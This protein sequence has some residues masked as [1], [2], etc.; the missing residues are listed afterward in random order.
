[1]TFWTVLASILEGLGVDFG[2]FWMTFLQ[3]LDDLGQQFG[4][5]HQSVP[6]NGD[7]YIGGTTA[8]NEFCFPQSSAFKQ[9]PQLVEIK[10]GELLRRTSTQEF[11]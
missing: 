1:M 10:S 9:F 7:K 8:E 4:V 6:P 5:L 11:S 3:I 2:R